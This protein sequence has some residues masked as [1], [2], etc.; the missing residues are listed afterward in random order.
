MQHV[1][2][3]HYLFPLQIQPPFP[4]GPRELSGHFLHTLDGG[5]ALGS[6]TSEICRIP[7]RYALVK[8]QTQVDVKLL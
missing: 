1:S 5:G 3:I 7:G 8:S 4:S 6:W 2:P